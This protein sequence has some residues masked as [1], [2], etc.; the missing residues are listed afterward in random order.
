MTITDREMQA[1]TIDIGVGVVGFVLSII[2]G[3][4][5]RATMT[6]RTIRMLAFVWAGIAVFGIAMV[7]VMRHVP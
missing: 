2:W 7:F 3:T 6:E 4:M 5:T 1:F